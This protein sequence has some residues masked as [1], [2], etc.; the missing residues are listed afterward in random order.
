[1]LSGANAFQ[2]LL[3]SNCKRK[4]EGIKKTN[5]SDM[6][7]KHIEEVVRVEKGVPMPAARNQTKDLYPFSKMEVGD[8]F[9][10]CIESK[11]L[12]NKTQSYVLACAKRYA[13]RH[14]P[15]FKLTS[16]LSPDGKTVRFWR[17][18]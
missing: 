4:D 11:N 3:M 7:N 10:L 17:C 2:N 6:N 1:M 18:R 9:E 12:R 8:S 5:S 16:R 14:D 15:M 13:I